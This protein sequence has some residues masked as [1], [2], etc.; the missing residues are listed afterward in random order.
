MSSNLLS[1][2]FLIYIQG[3]E[4]SPSYIQPEARFDFNKRY[5]IESSADIV[6]KVK[7]QVFIY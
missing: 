6:L 7:N 3:I 5:A 2:I 1:Y 4:F